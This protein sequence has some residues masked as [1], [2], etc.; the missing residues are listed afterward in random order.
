MCVAQTLPNT[1]LCPTI[2]NLLQ[3]EHYRLGLQLGSVTRLTSTD[4]DNQL[5]STDLPVITYFTT[6]MEHPKC[7]STKHSPTLLR[8]K[9]SHRTLVL[10]PSMHPLTCD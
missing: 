1:Q 6:S 4:Q 7:A 9:T 3:Y 2:V 5:T 8:Y 10:S